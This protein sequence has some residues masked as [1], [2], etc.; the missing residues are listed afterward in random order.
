MRRE[1]GREE[2]EGGR[3]VSL[4]LLRRSMNY[5]KLMLPISLRSPRVFIFTIESEIV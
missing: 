1:G 3:K 2:K 5:D 4:S